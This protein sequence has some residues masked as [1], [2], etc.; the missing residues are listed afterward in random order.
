MATAF[1][2]PWTLN[3]ENEFSLPVLP[4]YFTNQE[5]GLV[6]L[7]TMCSYVLC[8]PILGTGILNFAIMLV[9]GVALVV[10]MMR[11]KKDKP[12]S[13]LWDLK[14]AL[15]LLPEGRGLVG[16]RRGVRVLALHHVARPSVF[17]SGAS[18]SGEDLSVSAPWLT[19][20]PPVVAWRPLITPRRRR[21]WGGQSVPAPVWC[22]PRDALRVVVAAPMPVSYRW[23]EDQPGEPMAASTVRAA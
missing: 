8:A 1:T 23:V 17:L 20:L 21:A 16:A 14:L 22:A 6:I 18:Q 7:G 4:W 5:L 19:Q 10:W 13:W 12:A 15:G 9:A 2:V 11:Y 3:D